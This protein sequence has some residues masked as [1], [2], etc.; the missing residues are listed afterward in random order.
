MSI[1]SEPVPGDLIRTR[2]A[3]AILDASADTVRRWGREGWLRAW[4]VGGTLR[5]SESEVRAFRRP[6]VVRERVRTCAEDMAAAA[7]A[8]ARMAAARKARR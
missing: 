2:Q 5:F 6:V 4:Q 7:A 8:V 1:T 3:A